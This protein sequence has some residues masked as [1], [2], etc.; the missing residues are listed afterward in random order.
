[1][2]VDFNELIGSDL[3]YNLHSHTQFCDGRAQMEAFAAAAVA[4][5]FSVYGFTPHSPVRFHSPCNMLEANVPVYID[6]VRRLQSLYDGRI[7]FLAGMEIDYIDSECGPASPYFRQLALDYRIGSVHFVPADN[8][9]VDIDGR[10]ERFVEKM[11]R[12]F[13]NDIHHVIRL[14]FSQ[15]IAMVEAGGFDIVGHIDK[16]AHNASMFHPGIEDAPEYL[17]LINDLIDAVIA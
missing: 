5:G 9:Y 13:H 15:S 6:E 8:E 1:M 16:I 11:A 3:R 7:R 14:F 12:Y 4:A 17:R 10:F 2:M